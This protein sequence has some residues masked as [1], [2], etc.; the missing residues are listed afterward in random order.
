MNKEDPKI[1]IIKSSKNKDQIILDKHTYTILFTKI[2]QIIKL[3]I[4][5][6]N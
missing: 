1:E 3:F 2:K 5:Y 6:K 4:F